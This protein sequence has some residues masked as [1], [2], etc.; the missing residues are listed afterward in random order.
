MPVEIERKFL[1][2]GDGWR[3]DKPGQRYCQ[4]YI[5]KGNATVRVR[6]VGEAAFLTIK[7]PPNGAVRAEFEYSIPVDHAEELLRNF[8]RKPLVEKIRHRILFEGHCWFVDVFGGKH[9]GLVLAEIELDH[10]GETFKMPPWIG[11]EVTNDRR[12]GNSSLSFREDPQMGPPL[13]VSN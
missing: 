4:G 13:T 5:S 1:V 11:R 8:C 2:I 10:L 9:Q 7:G 6:R 3:P 12:Y